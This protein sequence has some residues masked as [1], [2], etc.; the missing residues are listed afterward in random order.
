LQ[1]PALTSLG[2]VGGI[3]RQLLY[4]FVTEGLDNIC[5]RSII[6]RSGIAFIF[7]HCLEQV[8]L[9]L[10]GNARNI[11]APGEIRV[12]AEIAA[13]LMH[14][15]PTMLHSSGVGGLSRWGWGQGG[16][17]PG[18]F[19]EFFI[20]NAFH[21]FIHHLDGAHPFPKEVELDFHV[22]CRLPAEGW[23]FRVDRG[24][25]SPWQARH[26]G[27][28]RSNAADQ[29]EGVLVVRS[30]S[31]MKQVNTALYGSTSCLTTSIE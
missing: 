15:G 12:V 13:V 3:I 22:G 27:R 2:P 28:R 1:N 17:K 26:V 14:K 16:E 31:I 25:F 5:H 11:L 21:G 6:A 24:P 20:T 9:P 30:A 8:V 18:K 7:P 23:D 29:H 10:A 19:G 4:V